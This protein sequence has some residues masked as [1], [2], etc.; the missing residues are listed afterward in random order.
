MGRGFLPALTV[1]LIVLLLSACAVEQEGATPSPNLDELISQGKAH[2]VAGDGQAAHDVFVI[3]KAVDPQHTDVAFGI[4]LSD[5]LMTVQLVDGVIDFALSGFLTDP[6]QGNRLVQPMTL[7]Q[8]P[9]I[10]DTIHKYLSSI[11]DPVIR[12]MIENLQVCQSAGDF[13]FSIE[14]V[15]VIFQGEER[16]AWEGLWD[17]DDLI[18]LDAVCRMARGLTGMIYSTDLNFD[19]RH[20]TAM[21]FD[22][23]HGGVMGVLDDLLEALFFMFH[24]PHYPRFMLNSGDAHTL[25]PLAGMDFGF[26]FQDLV[27]VQ[28]SVQL[29][30]ADPLHGIFAFRDRNANGVKDTGEPFTCNQEPIP[31]ELEALLPVLNTIAWNMRASFF[32]GTALDPDPFQSNEWN[33][34]D[35]NLLISEILQVPVSPIPDVPLDLGGY[36]AD[37]DPSD[38]KAFLADLLYCTHNERGLM[39]LTRCLLGVLL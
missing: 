6:G 4:F 3:A 14:R 31:Q 28:L 13:S 25:M 27:D 1:G 15:P 33:L 26:F 34:A 36:F 23:D 5:M 16:F 12:E 2:L 29:G 37:P 20:F 8:G 32:D 10:G 24:D 39:D 21:D 17:A 35:F 11:F 22:L 9:G 7:P 18:W 38:M 30:W 19:L